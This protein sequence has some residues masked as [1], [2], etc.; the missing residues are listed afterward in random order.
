MAKMMRCVK[1]GVS[2]RISS[3]PGTALPA[4]G[5]ILKPVTLCH[6]CKALRATQDLVF[7]STVAEA[8]W[9]NKRSLLAHV[10]VGITEFFHIVQL[11]GEQWIRA[12]V[13]VRRSGCFPLTASNEPSGSSQ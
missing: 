4:G 8:L 13:V 12:V 3:A 9:R 11:N 10:V 1:N 7:K 6:G 5:L 2:G